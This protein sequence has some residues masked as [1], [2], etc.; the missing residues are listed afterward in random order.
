MR[1][2]MPAMGV[3]L[4]VITSGCA[5]NLDKK[6]D[7]AIVRSETPITILPQGLPIHEQ[8]YGSNTHVNHR[9]AELSRNQQLVRYID[10]PWIGGIQTVARTEDRLP[11]IFNE[12][13]VLDFG[14]SRT[15]LSVVAARLTKLTNIPVRVRNDDASSGKGGAAATVSAASIPKPIPGAPLPSIAVLSSRGNS[16]SVV[17][18][19]SIASSAISSES[20]ISINAVNMK[21]NGRLRD[22]LDHLSGTLSMSWE[23]RDGAVIFMRF[24]TETYEIASFPGTQDFSTSTGGGGTGSAGGTGASMSSQSSTTVTQKGSMNVRESILKTVQEM[25]SKAPGSTATWAD[26]SGRMIVSTSKEIQGQVRDFLRKENKMLRTMVN[27]NFDIYS[28]KTTD[29]DEK[30]INWST[31]FQSL[32]QKYGVSFSTPTLLTGASAGVIKGNMIW[33][34]SNASSSAML[35]LLNQYGETSQHRPINITTL[36]GVWDTKSHLSTEGYLKETTPGTASSSGAAG[37]P[38]LKTDTVTTGDQ[39]AVV[40]YVQN[41]NTVILRYSVSLSDLLGMFDVST[42]SGESLQKVQTPRTE[43]VNA[44]STVALAPGETAVITGLSRLV[45]NRDSNRL[46]DGL[47]IALGGSQKASYQREHFLILVRATPL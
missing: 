18:N 44:S 33:D 25:I 24:I 4:C 30:G 11:A 37:A 15:S 26:G 3:A 21:W 16:A 17:M 31:V 34:G 47:P 38:G 7:Q 6:I 2:S 35:A 41:D 32:N 29:T 27:V 22:F 12:K 36:N 13:F 28:V 10:A 39:F 40:P 19:D 9:G 45:A 43:A 23:Y 42:G 20:E 5:M 8:I 46:A 1:Y 14:N